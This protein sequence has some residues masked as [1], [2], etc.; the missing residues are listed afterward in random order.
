MFTQGL[1]FLGMLPCGSAWVCERVSDRVSLC[2]TRCLA[3]SVSAC[4]CPHVSRC[5]WYAVQQGEC[6]CVFSVGVCSSV[7][8]LRARVCVSIGACV[9]VD[10]SGGVYRGA[11]LCP[12][13]AGVSR[14]TWFSVSVCLC[15]CVSGCVSLSRVGATEFVRAS[16]S[17]TVRV[18][19][20]SACVPV[21]VCV[22]VQVR[23]CGVCFLSRAVCVSVYVRARAVGCLA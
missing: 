18:N 1:V 5:G 21:G 12:V 8:S 2:E 6:D 4:E 7:V 11:D 23:R 3:N 15:Q 20:V 22:G 17:V 13:C 10:V 19:D 16:A 14:R 9:S